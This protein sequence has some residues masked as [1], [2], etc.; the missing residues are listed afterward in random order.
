MMLANQYA[1]GAYTLVSANQPSS[2]SPHWLTIP[3][4]IIPRTGISR[5]RRVPD[6]E[7]NAYREIIRQK[8]LDEDMS[9]KDLMAY[10][11]ESYG[12]PVK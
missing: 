3:R 1:D 10:M 6:E 2:S 4:T 12:L 7:W 9:L 8:Y 11:D 5:P